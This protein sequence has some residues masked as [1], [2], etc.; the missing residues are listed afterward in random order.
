MSTVGV[1]VN[2][3]V[4]LLCF[5]V[6][7]DESIINASTGVLTFVFIIIITYFILDNFVF[8]KYTRYTFTVYAVFILGL[9][10]LIG[11]LRFETLLGSNRNL[12][13]ASV[14][15]SFT[16]VLYLIRIGLFVYRMKSWRKT[17]SIQMTEE[18]A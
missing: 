2:G 7:G 13:Y 14:I 17:E 8:A 16:V 11:R 5:A 6:P 10:G 18:K 1:H 9:S 4:L 15:L 3:C 12:I